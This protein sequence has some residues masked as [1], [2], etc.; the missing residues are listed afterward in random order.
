M[1]NHTTK[2]FLYTKGYVKKR[3]IEAGFVVKSLPMRYAQNDQRYWSLLVDLKDAGKNLVLTCLKSGL[4]D[5]IGDFS[6]AGPKSFNF[7]IQTKSA[8]VL[9]EQLKMLMED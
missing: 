8:D 6:V 9:V 4:A 1:E 5:R 2:N 7:K 3:L